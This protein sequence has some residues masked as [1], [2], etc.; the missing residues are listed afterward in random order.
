MKFS[1]KKQL[2]RDDRDKR[3][4]KNKRASHWLKKN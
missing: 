4:F 2:S 1:D 3:N